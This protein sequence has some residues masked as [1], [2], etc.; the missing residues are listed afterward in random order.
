A[1]RTMHLGWYNESL[2]K[3]NDRLTVFEKQLASR[4]GIMKAGEFKT[5][6]MV[7]HPDTGPNISDDRRNEAVR[8]LTEHRLRLMH[9]TEDPST[10]KHGLPSMADLQKARGDVK[11]RNSARAKAAYAARKA[12]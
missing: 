2:K 7:C 12:V 9:E 11:A 1:A 10:P 5:L 3:W 6:M 8:I 4:R